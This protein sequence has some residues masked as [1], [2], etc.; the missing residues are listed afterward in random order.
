MLNLKPN[1]TGIDS[2]PD[3]ALEDGDRFIV[4]RVPTNA[5]VEGQVYSSN[6]FL[7][8][9]G[10][11]GI[12]LHEAGWPD[13]LADHERMLIFAR[14]WIGG[15]PAIHRCQ[16]VNDLSGRYDRGSTDSSVEQSGAH[17]GHCADC[18]E[19]WSEHSVDRYPCPPVTWHLRDGA[20]ALTA[21]SRFSFNSDKR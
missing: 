2:L 4:P 20:A 18:R 5:S 16:E 6:A 3:I 17:A 21:P 9:Q 1:D 14:G 8:A 12:Y 11:R 13:R 15:E 7:Y 10:K 19:P